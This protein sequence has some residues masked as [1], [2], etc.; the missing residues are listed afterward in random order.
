MNVC[1]TVR[2]I[3][4]RKAAEARIAA[5]EERGRLILGSVNEGI[6]GL[7]TQGLLTFINPAVT[8]L[9]GYSEVEL[10]GKNMH[11]LMHHTYPDGR[12][13]P[14][15][16][17]SM[18]LTSVDG[19]ARTVDNE[20]LWH[21]SGAAIP[22][23]Y[24]TTPVFK[25]GALVGTVIAFRDITE[26]K[27]SEEKLRMA[28]FL[29]DQ[30]LDLTRAGHWHIPLNTG[31]EFYNSSERAATI[32]GDPPRPDWRYHLMNE[33][34]AC[35]EAGDKDAAARTFENFNASLAGT[36]P[37]YDATYAY[38]RP[39][40]GQVI[41][42]HAMGHVVRDDSGTPT[43]M[44]GVTVDVTAT[45]LAEAELEE[46]MDELE[47]FHS[48]TIDREE[49]MIAL[50]GEINALLQSAGLAPKYKIVT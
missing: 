21:K 23:E 39:I 27:A 13:F 30:A 18:Y 5:L 25:D 33:W 15:N 10:L 8:A 32:F 48:L 16:E 14:R 36:V 44:F 29:N 37:R 9:L 28:N 2:D 7:D 22:V 38:K 6:V 45:K 49:R 26:R 34:F 11:A 50:K 12:D 1:A 35:V 3:T 47:R 20:V 40:D 24:S 31:D 43:D 46:R 17:C 42:V 41:W 19:Q 4:E